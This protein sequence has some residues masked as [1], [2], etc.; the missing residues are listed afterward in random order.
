MLFPPLRCHRPGTLVWVPPEA[1][2]EAGIQVQVVY[3]GADTR[4]GEMGQGGESSRKAGWVI[5]PATKVDKPKLHRK[6]KL[7]ETVH[8]THCSE[9]FYQGRG[10]SGARYQL[11]PRSDYWR[12][13]LGPGFWAAS[14][15]WEGWLPHPRT[16]TK[17][18]DRCRYKP[19]GE[20]WTGEQ[21]GLGGGRQHR[22]L[23]LGR[24]SHLVSLLQLKQ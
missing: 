2:P 1:D 15:V 24:T 23:G 13:F 12:L 16:C 18:G 3:L 7:W 8:T 14:Q 10:G 21:E 6:G 20:G 19:A 9:S 17:L 4:D 5:K 11:T 22:C